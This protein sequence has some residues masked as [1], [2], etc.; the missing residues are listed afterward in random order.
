M[1]LSAIVSALGAPFG[2]GFLLLPNATAA[3]LCFI[4]FYVAGA[5]YVGPLWSMTQSLARVPMRATAS[6]ILLFVLNIV[7]LGLGPQVIGWM[8]D[9]LFAQHGQD[10]IRYSLVVVA[11]IGGMAAIFFVRAARTLREDLDAAGRD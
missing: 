4:P 10:A 3:L 8:N 9:T 1:W 2:V 7:G 6:A 5:A 11:I